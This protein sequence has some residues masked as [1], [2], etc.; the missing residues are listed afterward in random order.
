[1][2]YAHGGKQT[3][4]VHQAALAE[5]EPGVF[6]RNNPVVVKNMAMNQGNLASAT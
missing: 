4:P 2:K 1:L 5:R 6:E 3:P